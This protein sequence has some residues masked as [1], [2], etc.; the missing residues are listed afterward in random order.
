MLGTPDSQVCA[1]RPP[2]ETLMAE[3]PT[4]SLSP[5]L[6]HKARGGLML[7]APLLFDLC[8]GQPGAQV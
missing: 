6:G 1:A 5:A 8:T 7:R 2:P 4:E 3:F